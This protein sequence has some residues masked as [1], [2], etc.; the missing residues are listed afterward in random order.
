MADTLL[1]CPAC[2]QR[3]PAKERR[4]CGVCRK[5]IL[6]HEKFYF[7]GCT[8]KHRCCEDPTEYTPAKEKS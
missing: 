2:G 8:V 4:I 5:P 1:I 3:L 6:R 7:D